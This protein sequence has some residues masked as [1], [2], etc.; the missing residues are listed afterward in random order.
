MADEFK[1]YVIGEGAAGAAG[2]ALTVTVVVP[3]VDVQ[4]FV[5]IVTL[6]VPP[7]AVVDAALVNV[8]TFPGAKP[9][10]VVHAYVAPATTGVVT[11]KPVPAQ[12][13]VLVTVGVVI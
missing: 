7:I 1:Q 9:S 5:V 4:P 2:A 10:G 12:T 13:G 3:A 6:Y 11:T 8:F